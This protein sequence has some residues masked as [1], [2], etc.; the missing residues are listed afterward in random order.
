MKTRFATLFFIIVI[1]TFISCKGK[2]DMSEFLLLSDREAPLG[3]IH[4]TIYKDSTFEYI[5]R[6]LIEKSVFKGK[7]I[8]TKDTIFLNYNDSIPNVGT[9]VIYNKD[10]IEFL[11]LDNSRLMTRLNKLVN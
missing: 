10:Y 3:W 8:I 1:I 9:K 4:F 6:G 7:A 5:S 2:T 11:E